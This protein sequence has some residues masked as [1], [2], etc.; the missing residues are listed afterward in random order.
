MDQKNLTILSDALFKSAFASNNDL[1]KQ[2]MSILISAYMKE[3]VSVLEYL[4]NEQKLL[5]SILKE[6]RMDAVCQISTLDLVDVEVQVAKTRKDFEKRIV[7]YNAQL[8]V[9]QES[10]RK[11]Y[12]ELHK[13]ISITLCGFPLNKGRAIIDSAEYSS[14]LF[15]PLQRIILVDLTLIGQMSLE[16]LKKASLAEKLGYL[17]YHYEK[18]EKQDIIEVIKEDSEVCIVAEQIGRIT[19]EEKEA[20]RKMRARLMENDIYLEEQHLIHQLMT[21]GKADG[22]SDDQAK[23][24]LKLIEEGE[25]K[26]IAEGEARGEA[27][28]K[29]EGEAQA[30]RKT[31][32]LL[33]QKMSLEEAAHLLEMSVDDAE[34]L[35]K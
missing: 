22:L 31:L 12:D 34:K 19:K 16:E 1:S 10:Y 24:Y 7:F 9:N 8:L 18:E 11:A 17:L 35:L 3:N 32:T 27:R 14:D 4:A 25:A 13:A 23:T 26:G 21:T 15:H 29:A 30:I 28:G 20:I 33:T 6:T 5:N 2:A